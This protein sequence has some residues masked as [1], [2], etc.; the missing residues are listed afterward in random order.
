MYQIV[1]SIVSES[2]VEFKYAKSVRVENKTKNG[3]T[4][5]EQGAIDQ[6]A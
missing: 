3:T 1:S 2:K 6:I 5:V 4:K